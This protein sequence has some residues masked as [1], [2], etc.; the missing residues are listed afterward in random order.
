M[1]GLFDSAFDDQSRENTAFPDA[2][3]VTA[4]ELLDGLNDVKYLQV[5]AYNLKREKASE[6][7]LAHLSTKCSW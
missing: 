4:N 1:I 5:Q 6:A 3:S 7:I 2:E